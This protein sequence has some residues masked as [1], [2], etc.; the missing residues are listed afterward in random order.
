[1]RENGL[2]AR[3]S[4]KFIWTTD[5]KH[6]FEVCPNIVNRE[7][8][9]EEGGM[10]WVSDIT[11]LRTERGWVYLTVILDL[12]DR[13]IIGWAL[14]TNDTTIAAVEMAVK[15]RIPKNG[16]IFHSDRGVQSFRRVSCQNDVPWYVRA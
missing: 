15:N 6:T 4:R 5:S 8:Y 1:M 14:S 11:Y 9:A 2:N 16:L 13:K 7:F 10:K 3:M 12:Y